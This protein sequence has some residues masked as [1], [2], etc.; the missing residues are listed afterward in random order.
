M[1]PFC[2][3]LLAI[4]ADG[5]R[6]D[7]GLFPL[8]RDPLGMEA[9]PSLRL[10]VSDGVSVLRSLGVTGPALEALFGLELIE[11]DVDDVGPGLP[12]S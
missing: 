9:S 6:K 4:E 8:A 5:L 7:V 2:G 12:R 1:R 11:F 10:S 3:S